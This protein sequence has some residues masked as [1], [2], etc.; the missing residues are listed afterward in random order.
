MPEYAEPFLQGDFFNDD[1]G[2]VEEEDVF[3]WSVF[4]R[5]PRPFTQ[6]VAGEDWPFQW[7]FIDRRGKELDLT[8]LQ[9]MWS[10]TPNPDDENPILIKQ[11][12]TGVMYPEP[13]LVRVIVSRTENNEFFGQYWHEL[14]VDLPGS[15][16]KTIWRGVI[17]V[18]ASNRTTS[19]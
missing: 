17:N 2:F 4:G 5:F 14:K 3:S 11:I 6:A 16:R 13:G 10:L 12:T 19:L 18:A 1:T 15:V 7:R 9:V 8:G